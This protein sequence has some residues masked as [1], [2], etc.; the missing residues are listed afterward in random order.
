MTIGVVSAGLWVVAMQNNK[1]K[2]PT[3]SKSRYIQHLKNNSV[4]L[5]KNFFERIQ[6]I[7]VSD[8]YY[9]QVEVWE[10]LNQLS[11]MIHVVNTKISEHDKK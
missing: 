10:D 9:N 8:N 1:N 7:N 2:K 4:K 11:K 5:Q 6:H 3:S